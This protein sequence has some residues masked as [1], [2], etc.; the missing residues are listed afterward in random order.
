MKNGVWMSFRYRGIA[1]EAIWIDSYI[2]DPPGGEVLNFELST[3]VRPEV[4]T[5]T[6]LNHHQRRR[7]ITTYLNH[8]FFEG[9]FFIPVNQCFLTCK[10]WLIEYILTT[11][12]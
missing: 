7:E 4:L 2:L 11:Y 12:R 8:L 5:T 9:P 3:E 1:L 10:L 6:L